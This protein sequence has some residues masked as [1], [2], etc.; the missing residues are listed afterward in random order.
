MFCQYCGSEIKE[1]Q[2]FC[3]N[4]GAEVIEKATNSNNT[5]SSNTNSTN[6]TN[7]SEDANGNKGLAIV[8]YITWVGFLVALILNN[9]Q[10]DD[11]AKFHLNQALLV[12]IISLLGVLPHVGS[13]FKLIA[14]VFYILGVVNA[15]QGKRAELPVIGTIKLI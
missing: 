2:K 12:H 3:T 14:V 1:N 9:E 10:R 7:N 8:A 15:A 13:L 4:C 5:N 11:F 6:A